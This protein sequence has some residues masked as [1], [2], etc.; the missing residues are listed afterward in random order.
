YTTPPDDKGRRLELLGRA[1]LEDPLQLEI[2]DVLRRDLR[3][4]AVTMACVSPGVRQPVMRFGTGAQQP[5]E[6]HL[7]VHA[8]TQ[9]D[10][11]HQ[12]AFH[13][14]LLAPVPLSVTR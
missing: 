13:H 4:R 12:N 8:C 11:Q 1:S 10:Y 9:E 6:G 14:G 3:Q 5:I 2:P 7:R